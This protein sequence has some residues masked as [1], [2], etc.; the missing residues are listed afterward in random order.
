MVP[1]LANLQVPT[2]EEFWRAWITSGKA[3]SLMPAF[4][5]S[6]GG[7]LGDLQVASLATY[8]NAVH[9]SKVAATNAPAK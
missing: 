4:A 6:Q 8:L 9:P 5:S 7:P 3:G 2:N 1:D